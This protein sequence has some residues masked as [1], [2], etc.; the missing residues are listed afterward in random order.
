MDAASSHRKRSSNGTRH[1]HNSRSSAPRD[2]ERKERHRRKSTHKRRH[3]RSHSHS[4][5]RSHSLSERRPPVVYM[6]PAFQSVYGAPGVVPQSDFEVRSTLV[7]QLS[8]S[9]QRINSLES[10]LQAAQLARGRAEQTVF[11]VNAEKLRLE[12]HN[13]E[14]VQVM[15]TLE[16]AVE[17]L[18]KTLVRL[19]AENDRRRREN[20][21]VEKAL[22]SCKEQ[23]NFLNERNLKLVKKCEELGAENKSILSRR[24]E[25]ARELAETRPRIEGLQAELRQRVEE[26]RKI[27]SQM[28]SY[29]EKERLWKKEKA[30][31]E[32]RIEIKDAMATAERKNNE[33]WKKKHIAERTE[34]ERK[35]KLLEPDINRALDAEAIRKAIEE[36]RA[37]YDQKMGGMISEMELLKKKFGLKGNSYPCPTNSNNNRLDSENHENEPVYRASSAPPCSTFVNGLAQSRKEISEFR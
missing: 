7:T 16:R 2:E 14:V 8:A 28:R 1:H 4:R 21:N 13:A 17:D 20:E 3:H 24:D 32:K 11:E 31:F 26:S 19:E 22:A 30:D 23:N 5:S 6:N 25:S 34:L 10:E 15:K 35:V 37:Y 33:E 27:V 29:E 36:I 9:E 18:Q 12:A